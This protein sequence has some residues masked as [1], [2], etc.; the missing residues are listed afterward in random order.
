MNRK[1]GAEK[2][3]PAFGVPPIE[4]G[5]VL[6]YNRDVKLGASSGRRIGSPWEETI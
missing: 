3:A 1:A 5:A 6:R 4:T 2:S